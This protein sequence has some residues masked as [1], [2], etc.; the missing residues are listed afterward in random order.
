MLDLDPPPKV[1]T[2]DCYGTLVQWPEAMREAIRAIFRRRLLVDASE[3][4]ACVIADRLREIA[5]ELQ[6]HRPFQQYG[7]VLQASLRRAVSEAGYKATVED[8]DTLRATLSTIAPHPEV[9]AAL[10]RL[11]EH[12]KIAI[13][14]N[15]ADDLIVGT[16]RAIGVPIDFV[17]TAEQARAYKPDHQLFLKAYSTMGVTRQET[18]H[19]GMGQFTDLK[20]CRELGVRSIWIDRLGEPLNPAWTPDVTLK[21]LSGLPGILLG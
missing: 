2:F 21:D 11:R 10:A 13:I 14:S 3:G 19:V 4:T 7:A 9:P 5:G 16:V 18:L 17:I 15:T 20:V 1:I 12:Y 6:E 8:F